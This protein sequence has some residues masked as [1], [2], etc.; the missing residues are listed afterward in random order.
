MGGLVAAAALALAVS[1]AQVLPILEYT[2]MSFRAAESEGF[3]DIYPY[4]AHPLQLLDAVW[5]NVFG[6]LEGGYRSWLNE[7]PPKVD[8]RFWM[9]SVYLG[10]LTLVLA[11]ASVG[12]RGGPPWRVWLSVVAIVSLLGGLGY[13]ASPLLW[14][15]CVPG[16]SAAL[17]PIEP[18][19]AWQV[20]TDG[21]LRDGDGGV[22][23]LLASI[24]PGFRSFRYPPKLFVLTSLAVSGLAGLGLG[25]AGGGAFAACGVR[26]GVVA[27][28]ELDRA[29]GNLDRCQPALGLVR[30]PGDDAPVLGRAA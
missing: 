1:G 6:T 7:L 10:G 3:H 2:A 29:G 26:C 18:P 24:L 9:P 16:W 19:F 21:N 4:S 12:V 8:S 14:A 11:S 23:W 22:Y 17:G 25:P 28:R 5:P 15:R 20:R 30:S 27:H 13:Y